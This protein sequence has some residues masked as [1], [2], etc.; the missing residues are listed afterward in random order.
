MFVKAGSIIP[1]GPVLRWV[2]E[3]EADPLTLDVYPAGS[4]SYT[5]YEDDGISEGYLGGAYAT[6]TFTCD[7][8]SGHA[9]VT[10][11][12]QATAKYPFAGQLCSRTYVLKVEGQGSR[13]V[14][15]TREGNVEPTLSALDFAAATE[16][17]YY[18][19]ATK[20]VWLKFPLSSNA[21]TSVSL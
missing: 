20:T 18:D 5:L 12:S 3:F 9:V 1:L 15:V 4:T 17:W 8:T 11:G 2:D 14:M 10:I 6:T 21:M 7:D 16:G 13:P 19:G